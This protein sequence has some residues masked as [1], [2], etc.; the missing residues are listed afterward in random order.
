MEKVFID[1]N[2][3]I[4]LFRG[5][6]SVVECFRKIESGEII[7][8]FNIVVFLETLNVFAQLSLGKRPLSLKKRPKE[9][10]KLDLKPVISAFSLLKRL[11]TDAIAKKKSQKSYKNT[12]YYQ[13]TL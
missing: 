6:R 5:R 13:M 10:S 1:T 2:V 4:E 3:V 7:G 8:F 9:L 11:P 12:V